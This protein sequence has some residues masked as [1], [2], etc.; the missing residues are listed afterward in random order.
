MMKF[1]VEHD[2]YECVGAYFRNARMAE[3]EEVPDTYLD[4]YHNRNKDEGFNGKLKNVLNI[5]ICTK[6]KYGDKVDLYT[7][8]S[9][10]G[11]LAVAVAKLQRGIKENLGSIAYLT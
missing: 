10:V 6:G 3:Y 8:L 2:K 9:L 5:E 4:D 7:T 11:V 1:L